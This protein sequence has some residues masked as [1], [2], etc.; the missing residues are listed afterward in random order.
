M[1]YY[2][3]THREGKDLWNIFHEDFEGFTVDL[4]GKANRIALRELREYLVVHVVWVRPP[5]GSI[6]YAKVFYECLNKESPAEWT[7]ERLRDADMIKS[8]MAQI[9]PTDRS[10]QVSQYLLPPVQ[11]RT[12]QSQAN[13]HPQ[14]QPNLG[15]PSPPPPL[16]GLSPQVPSNRFPAFKPVTLEPFPSLGDGN[17]SKM[18][19]EMTKLCTDQN[20]KFGGELY[21]VLNTKLRIFYDNCQKLGLPSNQFHY[22]YSIML[23]GRAA[24]FYYERL[25]GKGL[26]FDQMVYETRCHFETE[27]QKQQ[28]L[29]EW[30]ETTL[31]RVIAANPGSSRPECL[32]KLFDQLQTLQRGLSGAYQNDLSLR[33][34]LINACRGVE[35]CSLA[36][37]SP[38]PTYDGVYAQLRSAVSTALR[39]RESQQFTTDSPQPQLLDSTQF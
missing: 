32:E 27:E 22:A 9:E 4:F 6:S 10:P 37:Y 8:R 19:T 12:H 13:P 39:V 17:T 24:T 35:E 20:N 1:A 34:Q 38:A 7:P 30:R 3:R 18:L 5:R 33:D 15:G 31:L 36:P 21:D 29:S 23:K 26:N 2:R 14:V 16:P 11:P 25:A 28:Y